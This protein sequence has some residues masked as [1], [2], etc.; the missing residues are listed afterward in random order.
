[1]IDAASSRASA[2]ASIPTIWDLVALRAHLAGAE[3]ALD[4]LLWVTSDV[5]SDEPIMTREAQCLDVERHA[6]EL[7]NGLR[8]ARDE[9]AALTRLI[10][11]ADNCIALQAKRG[12][13]VR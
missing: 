12:G 10:R 2:H 5:L 7:R 6:V 3:R 4:D 11:R 13:G 8:G 1:M 9:L